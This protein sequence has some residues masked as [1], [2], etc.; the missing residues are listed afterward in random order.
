MSKKVKYAYPLCEEHGI[1]QGHPRD[2]L[3]LEL[4]QEIALLALSSAAGHSKSIVNLMG[5]MSLF[6]TLSLDKDT[7]ARLYEELYKVSHI[8]RALEAMEGS[9]KATNLLTETLPS[10]CL[11]EVVT[12]L[13]SNSYINFTR[14]SRQFCRIY[15]SPKYIAFRSSKLESMKFGR[16]SDENFLDRCTL[17]KTIL[18]NDC[19]KEFLNHSLHRTFAKVRVLEKIRVLRG[20]PR[21]SSSVPPGVIHPNIKEIA[22]VDCPLFPPVGLCVAC[23]NLEAFILLRSSIHVDQISSVLNACPKV[24]TLVL[25]MCHVYCEPEENWIDERDPEFTRRTKQI[26]EILQGI[27][28]KFPHVKMC[29]Q[30]YSTHN[31]EG[32]FRSCPVICFPCTHQY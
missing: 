18:F 7:V 12:F 14:T 1:L 19:S 9:M 23:P 3:R 27:H 30:W 17:V 5:D 25:S 6:E 15:A 8:D 32:Y 22:L 2:K 21:L 4:R 29:V 11:F 28:T 16:E 20:D 13:D 26:E 31:P 10:E 24:S